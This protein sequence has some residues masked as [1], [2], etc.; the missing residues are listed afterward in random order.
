MNCGNTRRVDEPRLS[1]RTGGLSG[2][3]IFR[4]M[5]D[6]VRRFA[7][8]SARDLEIIATGGIDAP[9]KARAALD[10]GATACA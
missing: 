6:N 2:P 10:A 4:T 3:A 8:D 7:T 5:L 1:Q 9:D